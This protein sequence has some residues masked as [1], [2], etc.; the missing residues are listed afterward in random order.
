MHI[1]DAH[2]HFSNLGMFHET[3]ANRSHVSYS[4]AGL[5]REFAEADVLLGIGM[6]MAETTPGGFPDSGAVN[7]MTLDLE[8]AV[9]PQLALC[10]GINPVRLLGNGHQEEMERIEAELR[11]PATVGIKVYAGYFHYDLLDPVYQPV[12]DLAAAY[13]LPVVIHSGDTYSERGLLKYSHPLTADEL[14]VRRR[15]VRF[16]LAHFGDPWIMETAEVLNKNA[17]VF[18]D[19]S[20]LV[21]GDAARLA[22]VRKKRLL[23]EHFQR[24]LV[25]LENYEQVLFGSDWPLAPVGPY[26]EFVKELV[27]EEAYHDVFFRNAL[28]VFPRLNGLMK[29]GPCA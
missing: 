8:P 11:Q 16:V 10:V 12:Y 9:P 7:P 3:A 15:D 20:G 24:G 1:I 28:R 19:L 4:S 17:N 2:L 18:A 27:P 23:M 26:I 29:G 5:L 14:A 25:Y 22:G 6:G 21:V 13:R